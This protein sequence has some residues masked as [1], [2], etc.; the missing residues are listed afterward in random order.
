M[1]RR[2]FIARLGGAVA[3]AAIGAAAVW[4]YVARAHRGDRARA[5]RTVNG[6]MS[7]PLSHEKQASRL[8]LRQHEDESAHLR[9]EG[10]EQQPQHRKIVRTRLNSTPSLAK[11][12]DSG[13]ARATTLAVAW[14]WLVSSL[15]TSA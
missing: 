8:P 10:S 11:W 7:G 9:Q 1:M 6:Q 14:V 5:P 3:A 13:R 15:M 4:R 2:E 12:L